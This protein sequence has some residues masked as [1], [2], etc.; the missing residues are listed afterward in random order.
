MKF[1]EVMACTM[2]RDGGHKFLPAYVVELKRG[3]DVLSKCANPRCSARMKYMHEG[4]LYVVPK[5]R[6]DT[7]WTSHCGEFSAPPGKQIEC[8]WLCEACSPQLTITKDGELECR[9]VSSGSSKM[10]IKT[11]RAVQKSAYASTDIGVSISEWRPGIPAAETVI[12]A[13][14]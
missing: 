14:N 8:F 4:S 1:A 12:S 11:G 2:L 9:N 3:A 13:A 6:M 5:P 7:Y 10:K